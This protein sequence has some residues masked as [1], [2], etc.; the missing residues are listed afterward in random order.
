MIKAEARILGDNK[1]IGYQRFVLIIG[2]LLFLIFSIVS[3]VSWNLYYFTATVIIALFF[4]VLL[5]VYSKV[6]TIEYDKSYF[7]LSNM[8]GKQEKKNSSFT[9]IRH[10]KTMPFL[11]AACFKDK[12]YYFLVNSHEYY[13]NLFKSK[14]KYALELTKVIKEFIS[15]DKI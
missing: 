6:Y 3:F 11:Y 12:K 7:Y 10:I 2:I 5:T 14:K 4:T 15:S 1:I 13:K 9:E 8:F